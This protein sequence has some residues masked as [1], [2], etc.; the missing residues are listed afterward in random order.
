VLKNDFDAKQTGAPRR[1]NELV[2]TAK[3]LERLQ[4]KRRALRRALKR[5]EADIRHEK[6]FLRALPGAVTKD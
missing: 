5:I 4:A 2:A 1:T 6:K 3:K